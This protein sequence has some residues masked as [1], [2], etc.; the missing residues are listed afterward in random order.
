MDNAAGGGVRLL[1]VRRC[2]SSSSRQRVSPEEPP[3]K[4]M[5]QLNEHFI[6]VVIGSSSGECWSSDCRDCVSPAAR[7]RRGRRSRR[8]RRKGDRAPGAAS[9]AAADSLNLSG[10]RCDERPLLLR[11]CALLHDVLPQ[12]SHFPLREAA[13]HAEQRRRIWGVDVLAMPAM[14]VV[15]RTTEREPGPART[16]SRS[17]SLTAALSCRGCC[18]R[19]AA[20]APP[21]PFCTVVPCA[22]LATGVPALLKATPPISAQAAR[23]CLSCAMTTRRNRS[24]CGHS[25]GLLPA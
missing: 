14:L 21:P 8:P 22:P 13:G 1:L 17:S 16:L 5:W 2:P 4:G 18:E 7:S 24:R 19:G 9:A 20:P 6:A 11:L 25:T 12:R 10:L 15:R 23:M 3:K